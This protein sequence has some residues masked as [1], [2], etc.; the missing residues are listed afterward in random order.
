MSCRGL[1][2]ITGNV[3]QMIEIEVE[4]ALNV[5]LECAENAMWGS[6]NVAE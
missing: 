1:L 4:S 3:L 5:F 2:L 6:W